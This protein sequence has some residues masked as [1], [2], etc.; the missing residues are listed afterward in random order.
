MI[1]LKDDIHEFFQLK[2]ELLLVIST[3]NLDFHKKGYDLVVTSMIRKLCED[4]KLKAVS[5]SHQ[6]GRAVDISI[7]GIDK[8]WLKQYCKELE[9]IFSDIAAI[10]A[11]TLK[12]RLTVIHDNGNG[13]H[14]HLQV[15]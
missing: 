2:P 3:I 13:Y 11:K 10:S 1:I 14:L 15:R 6:E 7:K 12:P 4:K 5:K 9:E 8:A